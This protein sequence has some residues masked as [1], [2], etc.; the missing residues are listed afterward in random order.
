M[1]FLHEYREYFFDIQPEKSSRAKL[2]KA[3]VI[4][5]CDVLYQGREGIMSSSAESRFE[6]GLLEKERTFYMHSQSIARRR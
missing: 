6:S 2:L 3:F 5:Y 1:K 4:P